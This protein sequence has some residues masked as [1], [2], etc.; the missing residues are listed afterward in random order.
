[1]FAFE[2]DTTLMA[3]PPDTQVVQTKLLGMVFADAEIGITIKHA[4]NIRPHRTT[5]FSKNLAFSHQS[6]G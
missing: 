1:M 4:S 2:F 6:V 5:W 3:K